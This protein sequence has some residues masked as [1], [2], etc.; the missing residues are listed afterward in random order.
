VDTGLNFGGK[1]W[2]LRPFDS[3]DYI[4]Q[5]EQKFTE[6]GAGALNLSV[7][8]SNA[9]LLSNELGLQIAGCFCWKETTWTF[10]PKISWVR[11]VRVHG[12]N[13]TAQ[14]EGTDA[15]F[16]VTGYF[17]DRSLVSPGILISGTML[18]G[19]LHLDLYYN[20][21]FGQKFSDHSFG[22]EVRFGF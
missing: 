7:Q 4:T 22:G 14:F 15:S 12:K 3:L 10:A 9:I 16:V 1:G 20:G 8:K 17:P 21:E 5:T 11:E 19:L 2:T 13:Y 6:S 18:Q